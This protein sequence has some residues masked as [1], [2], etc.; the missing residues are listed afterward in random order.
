MSSIHFCTSKCVFSLN[1]LKPYVSCV[2][3]FRLGFA[4]KNNISNPFTTDGNAALSLFSL[5][6]VSRRRH[7][8]FHPIQEQ[9]HCMECHSIN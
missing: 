1:N 4:Y 6:N 5:S 7:E 2:Q 9:S 3:K 8:H